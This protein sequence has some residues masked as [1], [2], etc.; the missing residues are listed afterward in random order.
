[1]EE[2]SRIKRDSLS[3]QVSDKLEKM[4][5]SGEYKIGQ[6]IPTEP[7]LMQLFA[8]SRN[9]IREAVK[10]LTWSGILEVKQGDGTYVRSA[11]RFRANMDK[12]Y[13]KI[14]LDDITEARKSIEIT[15]AYLAAVR[16]QDADILKI[17]EAYL[18]RYNT[19]SDSRENTKA[20]MEFHMAIAQACHNI[21][22]IELYQ[23]ISDY[24]ENHIVEK[25][26]DCNTDL[27]RID[28]LHEKLYQSIIEGNADQAAF[29]SGEIIKN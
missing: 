5:E 25:S 4:I 28:D 19:K 16:R 14:S 17:K 10:S 7:E 26:M 3:K 8:V 22:L 29:Y 24:L 23:S 21:I 11:N 12:T 9:T 18:K 13:S 20:D 15:I 6:K 2:I 1:M 27:D